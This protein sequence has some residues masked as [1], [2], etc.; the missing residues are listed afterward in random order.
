MSNEARQ[1]R[2]EAMELLLPWGSPLAEGEDESGA[3]TLWL[4][5]GASLMLWTA[6]ALLLIAV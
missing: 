5:G 6:V 2:T 1:A 3:A 4:A